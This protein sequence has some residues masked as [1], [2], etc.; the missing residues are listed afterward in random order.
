MNTKSSDASISIVVPIF[1]EKES[2]PVLCD[3][4]KSV[5]EVLKKHYE[6][7]LIDDCSTDGTEEVISDV[8]KNDQNIRGI[9]LLKNSRKAGA[10]EV[11]FREAKGDIIVTIDAD[12]QDDPAEIP[13]LVEEIENG[14]DMVSGWKKPRRDSILKRTFSEIMNLF[15]SVLLMHR[16]HDMNSGFK[17]YRAEIAKELSLPSGMYRFI[18][19]MLAVQGHDVREI[20][21]NHRPRKFGKTKFG[22]FHRLKGPVDLIRLVFITKCGKTMPE[23]K[24]S[25]KSRDI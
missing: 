16:F 6:I 5:L 8:A 7:L 2:I 10:L 9:R 14:A 23:S 15:A 19:H 1:N 22:L 17:A 20:V 25:Y 11:G 18:P 21:V 12:L 3:Q 4:I 24:N 13:R